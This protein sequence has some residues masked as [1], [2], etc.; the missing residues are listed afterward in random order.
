[1]ALSDNAIR[2]LATNQ[3]LL[4]QAE[5]SIQQQAYSRV[6][7]A[8]GAELALAQA[9]IKGPASYAPR[10]LMEALLANRTILTSSDGGT[11]LTANITDAVFD[12][13]VVAQWPAQIAE[14]V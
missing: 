8:T 11:T 5:V 1:M 9:I 6:Q 10:F 14:G 7:A 12:A 4:Q 2:I 13:A 3:V